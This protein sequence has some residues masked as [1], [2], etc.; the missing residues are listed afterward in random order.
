MSAV[1]RGI[2]SR[3]LRVALTQIFYDRLHVGQIRVD[4]VRL[5]AHGEGFHEDPMHAARVTAFLAQS[6]AVANSTNLGKDD[7]AKVMCLFMAFGPDLFDPVQNA[8]SSD[9]GE[10]GL[11]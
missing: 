7:F 10:I 5:A 2:C 9:N 1:A 3:H 4:L 11:V 6:Q 8:I